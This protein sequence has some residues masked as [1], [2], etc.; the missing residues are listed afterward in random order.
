MSQAF[1]GVEGH[2]AR[3]VRVLSTPIAIPRDRT[4]QRVTMSSME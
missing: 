2:G 4:N 1:S 3:P